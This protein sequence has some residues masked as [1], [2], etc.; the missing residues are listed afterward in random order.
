MA[1]KNLG[2]EINQ[3]R[4]VPASFGFLV[5]VWFGIRYLTGFYSFSKQTHTRY[6]SMFFDDF[7]ITVLALRWALERNCILICDGSHLNGGKY[8]LVLWKIKW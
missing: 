6:I 3:L 5:L 8:W 1:Y 2:D 7:L 4:L